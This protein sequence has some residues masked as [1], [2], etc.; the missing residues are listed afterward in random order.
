MDNFHFSTAECFE[1]CP[2]RFDF[3]YRQNIEVLPTDDPANPL[4]LG[5]AIHRGMEKDMETA[6]QEYKDS[7]PIITDAHINEII[8]LEY[9]IPKMKE[10]LPEGFHEV[11]FK[12]DVYEGTADLI[13][14]CTKHDAGLPHGQFDLY[15]KDTEHRIEKGGKDKKLAVKKDGTHEGYDFMKIKN[16]V[17]KS[18]KRVMIDLDD[19]AFDRLK[20]I[21][22]LRLSLLN[23]ELI[24]I[25][26][27]HNVVE[28]SLEQFDPRI[29]KSY[30][31]YRNYKK[32]FVHMMDK[33]YQKSQSIRFIGDKENAN[34]DS[35]LVKEDEI[36]K[37]IQEDK[38][39][40]KKNLASIGQK[41]YDA[42]HDI[43][44]YRMFYFN[45]DGQ[46]VED[47]TRSN[48]KISHPFFTELVDQAVQYMLSGE[49]GIIHSDRS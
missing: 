15:W 13:V 43:M 24:P 27:M 49:N 37:F 4:I 48:V 7:Y 47:T 46:L 18:A 5:T 2:A 10:L 22:E 23:T 35:T 41:Y 34:T 21:V 16:A 44:H 32:D 40:T 42:D 26:D 38:V 19:E 8:K 12:N 1:N 36:L 6:I 31:D 9:W 29:A 45:A 3:R 33:V 17:T 11:N 39:S 30:K 14:P 28:E 25:A 20:D